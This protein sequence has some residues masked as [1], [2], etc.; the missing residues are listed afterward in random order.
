MAFP[1]GDACNLLKEKEEKMT[2]YR[3]LFYYRNGGTEFSVRAFN[4]FMME[5]DYQNKMITKVLRSCA[6][7][8][9]PDVP[10]EL[11]SAIHQWNWGVKDGTFAFVDLV[12]DR[13]LTKEELAIMNEET[14]AQITDGYN[15]SP[16]EFDGAS[17][18]LDSFEQYPYRTAFA[19]EDRKVLEKSTI[20]WEYSLLEAFDSIPA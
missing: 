17:I 16:W 13:K 4:Q 12:C 10:S 14:R 3:S 5:D 9:W 20:G 11:G 18:M 7:R 8:D 19:V 15:E 2:I 1:R 6:G